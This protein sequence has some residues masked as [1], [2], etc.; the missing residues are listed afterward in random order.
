LS[1]L[2]LRTTCTTMIITN[3]RVVNWVLNR[4]IIYSF[5]KRLE[6]ITAMLGRS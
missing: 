5:K 3:N 2:Y 4:K 6:N 1:S